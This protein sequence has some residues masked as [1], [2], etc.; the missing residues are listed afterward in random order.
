M[1]GGVVNL[2]GEMNERGVVNHMN[3]RLMGMWHYTDK[4]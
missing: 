3:S 1:R 2:V 4:D